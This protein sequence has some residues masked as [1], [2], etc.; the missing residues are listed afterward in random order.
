MA[1]FEIRKDNAGEYRWHLEANNHKIIADSGEGY[2]TK[3]G[4]KRAIQTVKD[5]VAAAPVVDKTGE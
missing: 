1:T 5:D 4:C 2:K 3:D